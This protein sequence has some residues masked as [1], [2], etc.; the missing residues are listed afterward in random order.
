MVCKEMGWSY[1][2][3]M[4]TPQPVYERLLVNFAKRAGKEGQPTG[5]AESKEPGTPTVA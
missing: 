5:Q 4:D 3:L 1:Q 2:A